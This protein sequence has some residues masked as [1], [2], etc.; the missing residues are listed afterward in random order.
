MLIK[1]LF[2][3]N[4]NA[5]DW[6]GLLI[7]VMLFALPLGYRRIKKKDFS[8]ISLIVFSAVMGIVLYAF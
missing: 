1:N 3:I 5:V 8:S 4:Q 7:T 6:R 2:L